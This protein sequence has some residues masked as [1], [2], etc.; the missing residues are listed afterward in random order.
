[1]TEERNITANF[2]IQSYQLTV[3][4]GEGGTVSEGGSFEHGTK[5][6]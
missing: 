2:Q 6:K 1:M 4:A 3:L 5:L